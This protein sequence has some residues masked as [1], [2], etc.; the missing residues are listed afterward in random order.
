MP[1]LQPRARRVDLASTPE[2]RPPVVK[3][4]GR[5]AQDG[6]LVAATWSAIW[7]RGAKP[8]SAGRL[9]QVEHEAFVTLAA[10]R[11][12]T[13][14]MTAIAAGETDQGDALLVLDADG[15]RLGSLD[16]NEMTPGLLRDYW[17]ALGGLHEL[18]ISHGRVDAQ[19]LVVRTDGSA[20]LT[21]LG[22]A[23]VAAPE[24]SLRTDQA[25]LLVTTALVPI[26]TVPS[27]PP[28]TSSE[29]GPAQIRRSCSR[30]RSSTTRARRCT[31]STW[32]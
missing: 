19:S 22:A 6:Q 3:V 14:V 12:G 20:A 4:F 2:G 7:R 13:A 25:Q 1:P 32:I 28:A 21:D 31:T 10:E 9:E 26:P 23:H 30:P 18:G 5:D 11:G 8:V 24:G 16:A 17:K 27:R 15:R 29:R